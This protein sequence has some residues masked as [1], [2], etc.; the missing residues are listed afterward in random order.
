MGLRYA[1]FAFTE[2]GVHPNSAGYSVMEP[3]VKKGAK[4]AMNSRT[5]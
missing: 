2:D 5:D 4:K 1:P 3:P